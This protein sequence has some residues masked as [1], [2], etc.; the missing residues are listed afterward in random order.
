M[1]RIVLTFLLTGCLMAVSPA[2][3]VSLQK[4]YKIAKVNVEFLDEQ[5]DETS[6]FGDL[7][8]KARY[9]RKLERSNKYIAIRYHILWRAPST[10]TP[11]L[12]VKLEARGMDK[13]GRETTE[14]LTKSYP[15]KDHFSGWAVLDIR[16]D[17]LKNF[18][19]PMA[20]KATIL[21]GGQPMAERKSFTWDNA[22]SVPE[23]T[24]TQEP[25]A[26]PTN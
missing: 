8:E 11:D 5:G 20:W 26:E 13:T 10:P 3:E 22:G 21:R 9:Q 14:T 18:G 15:Q 16:G 19:K 1:L 7:V 17:A 6:A 25:A 4:G 24:A 12:A 23:P 2:E